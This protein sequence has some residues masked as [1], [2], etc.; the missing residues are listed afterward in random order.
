[1]I[2]GVLFILEDE[3]IYHILVQYNFQLPTFGVHLQKAIL[4]LYQAGRIRVVKCNRPVD[5][6]VNCLLS[7][8]ICFKVHCFVQCNLCRITYW[9]IKHFV[10]SWITVQPMSLMSRKGNHIENI[11]LNFFLSKFHGHSV[12]SVV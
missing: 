10:C 9:Y 1:M 7:H 11:K 12:T 8:L 6:M 5:L 2:K 3:G 4:W